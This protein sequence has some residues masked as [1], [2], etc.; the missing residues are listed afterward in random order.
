MF[1]GTKEGLEEET[2]P[3]GKSWKV[4]NGQLIYD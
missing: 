4:F 3:D 1:K 2:T